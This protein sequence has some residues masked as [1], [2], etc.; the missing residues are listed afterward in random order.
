LNFCLGILYPNGNKIL[1]I[2][3][4]SSFIAASQ[5]I[6]GKFDF[7]I[8]IAPFKTLGSLLSASILINAIFLSDGIILSKEFA[9]ISASLSASITFDSPVLLKVS[10]LT[11]FKFV[12]LSHK[13]ILYE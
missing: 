9:S 13:A 6:T 1:L 10:N 11:N 3:S 7:I 12:F 4:N 2:S 5:I 8:F